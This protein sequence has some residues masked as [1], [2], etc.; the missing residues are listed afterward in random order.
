M[1]V[2]IY[3]LSLFFTSELTPTLANMLAPTLGRW[4]FPARPSTG[5][6]IIRF[7]QVVPVPL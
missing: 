4:F 5:T 3:L 6:P 7:S 1:T 2:A